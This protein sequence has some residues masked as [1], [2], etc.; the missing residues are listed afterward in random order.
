MSRFNVKPRDTE[1][2]QEQIAKAYQVPYWIISDRTK[3]S[4]L[5]RPTWRARAI[6]WRYF[7]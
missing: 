2:T 5:K 3:P 7:T 4:W 6:W 1:I